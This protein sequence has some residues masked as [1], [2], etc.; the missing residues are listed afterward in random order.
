VGEVSASCWKKKSA[1]LFPHYEFGCSIC[2]PPRRCRSAFT[3]ITC[4]KYTTFLAVSQPPSDWKGM[5]PNAVA[6]RPRPKDDDGQ[7]RKKRTMACGVVRLISFLS[8]VLSCRV[9]GVVGVCVICRASSFV[10]LADGASPRWIYHLPPS[11]V[12]ANAQSVQ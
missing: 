5:S 8:A 11:V 4:P 12:R 7:P 6:H 2:K 10:L 3:S 9:R 1:E